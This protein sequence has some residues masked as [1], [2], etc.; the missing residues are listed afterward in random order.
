MLKKLK[1]LTYEEAI[2]HA[3]DQQGSEQ[4]DKNKSF[5]IADIMS[6][7]PFAFLDSQGN[8]VNALA[9]KNGINR[10]IPNYESIHPNLPMKHPF[11]DTHLNNVLCNSCNPKVNNELHDLITTSPYYKFS[12][13]LPASEI[14][15]AIVLA[16]SIILNSINNQAI[17]INTVDQRREFFENLK[18]GIHSTYLPPPIKTLYPDV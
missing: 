18:S 16:G 12:V 8:E 15:S 13:F 9:H 10:L 5:I 11:D 14:F 1:H 7:H 6:L 2:I 3:C 17:M 4:R